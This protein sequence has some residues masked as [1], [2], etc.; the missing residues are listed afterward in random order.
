MLVDAEDVY[1]F[2]QEAMSSQVIPFIPFQDPLP[3]VGRNDPR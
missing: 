1:S 2:A 3:E